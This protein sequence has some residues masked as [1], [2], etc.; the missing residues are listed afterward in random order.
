MPCVF[1]PFVAKYNL[2]VTIYDSE[3]NEWESDAGA[4]GMKETYSKNKIKK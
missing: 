1:S 3:G 4:W 2:P